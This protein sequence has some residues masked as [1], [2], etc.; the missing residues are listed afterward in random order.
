MIR[1]PMQVNTG[2]THNIEVTGTGAQKQITQ[3]VFVQR[4]YFDGSTWRVFDH[5]SIVSPTHNVV[6]GGIYVPRFQV[7]GVK[8]I[9]TNLQVAFDM[10]GSQMGTENPICYLVTELNNRQFYPMQVTAVYVDDDRA[11]TTCDAVELYG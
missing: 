3:A 5:T 9:G 10:P 1:A 7:R 11:L 4:L 8:I 2:Y 6:T